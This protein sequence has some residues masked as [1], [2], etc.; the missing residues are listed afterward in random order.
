M[1][2]ARP[3]KALGR[4]RRIH[5][6]G[7]EIAMARIVLGSYA[8]QFPLGGYLS[9]VLQWLGGLAELG[10]QG[11]FVERALGPH[12]RFD[13]ERGT[14]G[15]DCAYGAAALAGL[16][17]RHGLDGRWAFV[18]HRGTYHGLDRAAVRAEFAT[19]DLFIDMGTHETWADE[20]RLAGTRAL[21]DGE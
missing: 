3:A 12:A 19:A 2:R 14:M 1:R 16:L 7:T 15:D 17:A 4:A 18:D 6:G 11:A 5:R 13:P 21:V 10:H 20:S 8:V 9:W